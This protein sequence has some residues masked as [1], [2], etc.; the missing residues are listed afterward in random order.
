ML[1]RR[2]GLSDGQIA[3]GAE[4]V[5]PRLI[6]CAEDGSRTR[7]HWTRR[8]Q[9]QED[10]CLRRFHI[11][12]DKNCRDYR[13]SGFKSMLWHICRRPRCGL[14]R[15]SFKGRTSKKHPPMVLPNET[16]HR[17]KRVTT[18]KLWSVGRRKRSPV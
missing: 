5:T 8:I 4:G 16:G 14:S 12:L 1:S 6:G 13:S 17:L 2:Y 9:D 18:L 3:D 15:S 10:A 11:N 7:R